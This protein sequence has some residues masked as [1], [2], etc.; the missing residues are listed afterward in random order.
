M[1][2]FPKFPKNEMKKIAKSYS[3]KIH[4]NGKIEPILEY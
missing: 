3:L 4:A 2:I 1:K